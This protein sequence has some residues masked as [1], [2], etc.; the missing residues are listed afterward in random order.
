MGIRSLNIITARCLRK[1][2]IDENM[3]SRKQNIYGQNNGC[4]RAFHTVKNFFPVRGVPI[5]T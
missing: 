1:D 5:T 4:V 3:D 2:D